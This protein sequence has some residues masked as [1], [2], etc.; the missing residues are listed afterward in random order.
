MPNNG[1]MT[2]TVDK[3]GRVLIP[4][5]IRQMLTIEVGSKIDVTIN[6]DVKQLILTPSTEGKYESEIVYNDWGLPVIKTQES[7]PPDFDTAAFMKE[8]YEEYFDRKFG[9]L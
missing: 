9:N 8:T 4:K 2:L 5:S 6:S 7:L 1:K 3:F